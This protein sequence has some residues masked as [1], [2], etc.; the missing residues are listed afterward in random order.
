[1]RDIRPSL[2]WVLCILPRSLREGEGWFGQGRKPDKERENES[3]CAE[4]DRESRIAERN[5][6]AN[7]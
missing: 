2:C 1:M 3:K 5:K 4:E 6:G 7:E